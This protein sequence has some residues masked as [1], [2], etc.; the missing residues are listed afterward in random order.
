MD[1]EWM[2]LIKIV[3]QQLLKN[4]DTKK[5]TET[6]GEPALHINGVLHINI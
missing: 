2:E 5:V 6:M 1:A 4:V 3:L